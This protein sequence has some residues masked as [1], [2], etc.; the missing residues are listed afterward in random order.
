M[1]E[2]MA[3]TAAV[4]A[5]RGFTVHHAKSREDAAKIVLGYIRPGDHVG[6]GGSVTIR[7]LDIVPGLQEA[8]HAVHW[9]W[10]DAEPKG[11]IF[12]NAAVA[13]VYLT[14]ANAVTDQGLIVNTDRT[15]NRVGATIYGPKHVIMVVGANKLVSGGYAQAV[16]RIKR[17]ACPKNAVRLGL[18]TPCALTG[19]CDSANCQ[20]SMCSVTAVI[21]RPVAAHPITVVLVDEALGY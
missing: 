20:A 16:A 4:L 8:G 7:E 2:L 6:V 21:E 13:D 15:G 14:S 9:H 18:S 10:L 5:G 1:T 17:D 19:R 3:K 11:D 12:P